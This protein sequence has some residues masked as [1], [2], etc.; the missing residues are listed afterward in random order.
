LANFSENKSKEI[1][2]EAPSLDEAFDAVKHGV[3]HKKI[4]IL[5]GNCTV[6]Y[7]GRASSSL[8][9]GERIAIFK[10]DGSALIHRPKD[11]SPVNW[12]PPGSLFQTKLERNKLIIR[13][14]RKKDHE[15]LEVT[16]NNLKMIS[17][18]GLRDIG[19]FSLYAT[20]SDMQQAILTQ[21]S[22]IEDGFRPISS[23]RAVDPGFIDIMVV[24]KENTLTLIEIK[25][26]KATRKDA[27]QLKKYMD[28]IHID[29]QRKVRAILVA[30]SLAD[31]T[32]EILV[33]LGYEFK[34]LS[35]QLCSEIL[36]QKSGKRITDFFK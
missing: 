28:V 23:E 2:L 32:Q 7:E 22:L 15:V 36:K 35:P 6:E 10:P 34:A 3:S 12:Q 14:Y 9:H 33:S 17:V 21:P 18:M 26:L 1:F 29:P 24:D 4:V 13:V 8:G 19:E 11:Y 31:G 20:E 16:F 25:R 27:L 5:A 30:P